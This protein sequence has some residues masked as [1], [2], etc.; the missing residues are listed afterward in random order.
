M[1]FSHFRMILRIM[2]QNRRS[3]LINFLGLVLGLNLLCNHIQ[4]DQD[5]V[6]GGQI[7]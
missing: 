1:S 2:I 6:F 4:L 3:T 7:P 5:R